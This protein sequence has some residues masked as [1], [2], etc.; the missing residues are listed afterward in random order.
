M[1]LDQV[2]VSENMEKG[3]QPDIVHVNTDFSR[4]FDDVTASDHE[5]LVATIRPTR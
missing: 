3:A 1:V 4:M 5:P 2:F